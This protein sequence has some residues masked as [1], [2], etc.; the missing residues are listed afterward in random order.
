MNNRTRPY[1]KA[2]DVESLRK[3]LRAYGRNFKDD[4][5]I[6][7]VLRGI[8]K[9]VKDEKVYTVA[10][11][12]NDDFGTMAISAER[13]ALGRQTYMPSWTCE[14]F[15]PLIP[16]MT[17][18]TLWVLNEDFKNPIGGYGHPCDKYCWMQYWDAVKKEIA[19]RIANGDEY[20]R[21]FRR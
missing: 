3:S 1:I 21:F 18:H 9:I 10:E 13:Y 14:Y 7:V 8:N 2:I 20:F 4:E 6:K 5:A 19:N 16:F 11:I 15:I 17:S 12:D